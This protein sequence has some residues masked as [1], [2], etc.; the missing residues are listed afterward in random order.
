M[1]CK[2]KKFCTVYFYIM[3][4]TAERVTCNRCGKITKEEHVRYCPFCGFAVTH[5]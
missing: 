3:D 2:N 4:L 5:D 1:E